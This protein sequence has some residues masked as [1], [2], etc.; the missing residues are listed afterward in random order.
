MKSSTLTCGLF[1]SVLASGTFVAC[2]SHDAANDDFFTSGSHEA[3]Q[4]AEQRMAKEEQLS[5]ESNGDGKEKEKGRPP[6]FQRLGGEAGLASIVSDF[7]ERALADPRTNWER[8]GV[9]S[10]GVFGVGSRSSEWKPTPESLDQLKLHLAQFLQLATGGPAKY[11]GREMKEVHAKMKITND[12]FNACVGDLK[13]TLDKLRVPNG[14]QKELLA[15]VESTRPQ[16]V[17]KR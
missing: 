7:V 12:E 11:E 6:L 10:G 13:A 1:L 4:R 5:G 2:K 16:I 9:A 8:K 14:E 3:D 15:I 17:E